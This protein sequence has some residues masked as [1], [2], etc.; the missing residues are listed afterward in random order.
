MLFLSESTSFIDATIGI[1]TKNNCGRREFVYHCCDTEHCRWRLGR[2]NGTRVLLLL[3]LSLSLIACRL[4]ASLLATYFVWRWSLVPSV[5]GLACHRDGHVR[6]SSRAAAFSCWR[7][8]LL[9]RP[10]KSR[11]NQGRCIPPFG[12][13]EIPG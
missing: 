3:S 13:R 9:F 7:A 6:D 2:L 5:S 11:M 12:E 8:E 10:D 4:I 1:A